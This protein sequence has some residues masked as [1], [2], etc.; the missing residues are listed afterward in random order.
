MAAELLEDRAL[1]SV[2][3]ADDTG[4]M[5]NHDQPFTIDVLSNDS[6]SGSYDENMNYT[7]PGPLSAID[8]STPANGIVT[9]N[10][11]GT[12]TYTPNAN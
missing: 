2:T 4:N 7:P 9:A 10:S 6:A 11:N 8:I 12:L 3:A 1:L 5:T